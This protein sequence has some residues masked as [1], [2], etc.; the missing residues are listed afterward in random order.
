MSVVDT[1]IDR[2]H[3]RI[4]RKLDDYGPADD[5]DFSSDLVSVRMRK[6]EHDAVNSY[7]GP[8]HNPHSPF[9]PRVSDTRSALCSSDS[10]LQFFVRM[11]SGGNT[12]VFQ[13]NSH[14][15]VRSIHERIQS[16]VG[17][18]VIEQRLIYLGKQLQWEQ[19]LADCSIENDAGL[20]LVG[21]MR[22][23]EHPQAWQAIDQMVSSI[24]RMCKSESVLLGSYVKTKLI[25]FLTMTPRGDSE[26]AAGHLQ[27]FISS[28]APVALVMLYLS[29]DEGNKKCGDDLIR[30]VI[31][32]ISMLQKSLHQHF[33]PILLEFCKLLRRA[34]P[35]DAMYSLCRSSLGSMVE[36]ID[37]GLGTTSKS[38]DGK[39]FVISFQDVFPFVSELAAKLTHGLTAS[40]QSKT[41]S[42]PLLVDVHDFTS[43]LLPVIRVIEEQVVFGRLISMPFH[44]VGY[45][46]PCLG[47]DIN[48]LYVIFSDLL[49]KMDL[50]L[51]IME[52]CLAV[53][54]KGEGEILHLGWCQYLAILKQLNKISKLYQGAE[55]QFWTKL[56]HRKEAFG[57]DVTS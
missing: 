18:P 10:K 13:A 45:N 19:S 14:D 57:D 30:Q 42:G 27:I 44:D 49:E 43:F 38:A 17:I 34:S 2:V 15:T 47:E 21:R 52:K 31:T 46:V 56:M 24:Y 25:E 35:D 8:L 32:S 41:E 50:C 4:K 37:I 48:F 12:L 3:Q 11:I 26:Q 9:Q 23:T 33:A 39:K 51:S 6:D 22:S 29:P 16:I 55:K 36:Y 20:Q 1:S 7:A 28:C 53:K 54:E 40:V 5:D